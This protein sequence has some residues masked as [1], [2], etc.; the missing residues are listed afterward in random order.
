[1]ARAQKELNFKFGC[2]SRRASA[3]VWQKAK[4]DLESGAGKRVGTG[5]RKKK[6][7]EEERENAV[8]ATSNN[9]RTLD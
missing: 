7:V 9:A 2:A 6:E 4:N 1:M 5:K 8:Q 3:C